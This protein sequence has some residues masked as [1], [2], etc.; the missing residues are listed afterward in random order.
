[1]LISFLNNKPFQGECA[2]LKV[3]SYY[4]T[5]LAKLKKNYH[6]PVTQVKRA[7]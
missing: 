5:I 4:K 3:N 1:M 2:N 6:L 7:S